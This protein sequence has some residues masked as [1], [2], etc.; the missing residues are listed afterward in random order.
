MDDFDNFFKDFILLVCVY[1]CEGGKGAKAEEAN[2]KYM[3]HTSLG[4]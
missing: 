2:E 1:V 4:L 3:G